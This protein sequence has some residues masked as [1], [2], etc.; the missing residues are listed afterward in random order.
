VLQ[1]VDLATGEGLEQAVAAQRLAEGVIDF[2][3]VVTDLVRSALDSEVVR[4]AA[5]R[6]PLR[7][8]FV[9]TQDEDG[10]ML[11]G[12]VDLMYSG[13]DGTVV[14]VDYKTDAVPVAALGARV[15]FYRPQVLAYRRAAQAATG[16]A[17]RAVL[18][19]LNPVGLSWS[20]STI[21]DASAGSQ[22]EAPVVLGV[23]RSRSSHGA[24]P[25]DDG[26]GGPAGR[27]P[28]IESA[29]APAATPTRGWTPRPS[30]SC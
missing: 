19:F 12:I 18:L 24:P 25:G 20:R 26:I 4:T 28:S 30:N 9:G 6:S 17:T 22:A 21:G 29:V 13:D 11:E 2:A 8:S 16:S 7:E 3:A 15:E 14:I 1:S 23:D 27:P 10:T 5:A